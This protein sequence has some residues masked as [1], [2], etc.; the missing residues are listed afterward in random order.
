MAAIR[1]RGPGQWQARVRRKGHAVQTKIFESRS[2]AEQ[3][4]RAIERAMDVGQ[5][6]PDLASQRI[7]FAEL[8]EDYERDVSAA[9]RGH[10]Q[11]RSV[12]KRLK[13]S[14]LAD[15][16]LVNITP[17]DV[18]AYRDARAAEDASPATINR[19]LSLISHI[20][21]VAAADWGLH[22]PAG[23]PV[24][25]V[26]RPKVQNRRDRRLEPEEEQRLLLAAGEPLNSIIRLA[27]ETAMRRGELAE[28]S[29]AH[30]DLASRV[31]HLPQTKNGDARDVPLSTTAIDILKAQ[32]KNAAGRVFGVRADSITQAFERARNRAEIEDLRFHDLRHEATSRLFEKGVFSVAEIQSITG[33]KTMAML[34]RYTHFKAGALAAKLG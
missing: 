27:L 20:C 6:V 19:E 22:L 31:A 2:A 18:A 34:S 1:K 12:L 10:V 13:G 14:A 28:L 3:W 15:L 29:W 23:N 7:T 4:A 9:K 16:Y 17:K 26:R 30:V 5:Y 11:E 33:H 24:R 25:L 32:P 21:T 8:C